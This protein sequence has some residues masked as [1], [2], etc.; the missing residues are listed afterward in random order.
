M[1]ENRIDEIMKLIDSF[2]YDRMVKIKCDQL[3]PLTEWKT[4]DVVVGG[5]LIPGFRFAD[6]PRGAGDGTTP[7]A[8]GYRKGKAT[9][10]PSRINQSFTWN[11]ELIE[12]ASAA[13]S[14]EFVASGVNVILNVCVDLTR[15][16]R[17]GRVQETLGEDPYLAGKIG[18]A[19]VLG[20][21]S[22]GAIA[23]VKHFNL[24]YME[25]GR[26]MILDHWRGHVNDCIV[27]RR[28]LVEHYGLPFRMSI[29]DGGAMSV[30]AAF[31]RINGKKCTEN[32]EL[33]NGILRGLWGY[34]YWVISDWTGNISGKDSIDSGLDLDESWPFR[35][36]YKR[37][38][39]KEV[40]KGMIS[41]ETLDLSVRRVLR[42]KLE[43][44]IMD[45]HGRYEKIPVDKI[46]SKE[47]QA[48]AKTC[49][50]ESIVLLENRNNIL[51]L[52]NDRYESIAVIG[53]NAAKKN[54]LLGDNFLGSS[55]V[56]AAYR[57]TVLDG[58]RNKTGNVTYKK[59]CMTKNNPADHFL[60]RSAIEAA[61]K[62]DLIIFAG[63]LNSG[64]EGEWRDRYGWTIELPGRQAELINRLK[65]ETGK[66]VIVVL[67]GGGAMGVSR[68]AD[69]A[70]AVVMAGYPGME[71][72]NAVADIL[73]G[74]YNP[75][76]KLSVT[77]PECD[78][79]LPDLGRPGDR[80]FD[81]TSDI[82]EGVG[83]RYYDRKKISPRYAF[84]FGLSYT[85]FSFSNLTVG[86]ISAEEGST[87]GVIRFPVKIGVDVV[88]T[89]S[90][91]GKEVVQLYLSHDGNRKVVMPVKQLKAFKKIFLAPG[92]KKTVVLELDEDDLSYYDVDTD[93]YA[94]EYGMYGIRAGNSSDN[95]PLGAILKYVE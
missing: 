53:P 59:G 6:G 48:L 35:S 1:I 71:G 50:L 23:N 76:A 64:I 8:N 54:A 17:T 49:A 47:H 89:G 18:A 21:Q 70:D 15:D 38:L 60:M 72:G 78:D 73:F 14:E 25:K 13:M 66:P 95:L 68:F 30:M 85:T 69:S 91:G 81:F 40:R 10:F 87:V 63:G 37:R 45:H 7:P 33:L 31:N 92:E 12:E 67:T 41:M 42:T 28:T 82:S 86:G 26:G 52:K 4:A 80:V 27:D 93:G 43:S 55:F 9:S 20:T 32:P 74:D 77:F 83:Y 5:I 88:N 3:R 84:G 79:D 51:P 24:N 62:C 22:T 57:V 16:P 39:E 36:F 34:K 58:I 94:V 61:K 90:V 46:N 56:D 29:I 75:D 2:T 44:R 11:T 19:T 65:R